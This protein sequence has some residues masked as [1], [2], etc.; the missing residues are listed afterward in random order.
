MV[1]A[2]YEEGGGAIYL[3]LGGLHGVHYHPTNGYWQRIAASDFPF[4]LEGFGISIS[5]A[6]VDSNEYP[7]TYTRHR[8]LLITKLNIDQLQILWLVATYQIKHW[9]SAPNLSSV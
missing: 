6:D 5:S 1:G 3:Y 8:F 7:G 9:Y 4:P 2:P